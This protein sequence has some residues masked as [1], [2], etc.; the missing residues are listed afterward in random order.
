MKPKDRTIDL[1]SELA[2][3]KSQLKQVTGILERMKIDSEGKVL[4]LKSDSEFLKEIS[5]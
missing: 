1:N 4:I 5:Q 3:V 2:R